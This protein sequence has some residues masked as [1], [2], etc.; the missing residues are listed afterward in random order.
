MS[1]PLSELDIDVRWR[2]LDAN[3]HVNNAMYLSYLEEAR[4]VWLNQIIADWKV[5]GGVP[6]LAAVQLN[7]RRP[8]GYP[9]RVRVRQFVRRLGRSSLTL[10][11]TL[12][13]SNDESC[14]FADGEV[15]LV[16]A[17]PIAG[18]SMPL[19]EALRKICEHAAD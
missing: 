2:D 12:S 7:F 6:V 18:T 5:T 14:V 9:A 3:H 11:S 16:W 4:V 8:I 17:D 10:G 15:V 19:P 13:D 1:S